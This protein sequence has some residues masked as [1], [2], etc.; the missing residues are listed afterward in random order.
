MYV[1]SAH[2]S[3]VA[4][5]YRLGAFGWLGGNNFFSQGG[6]PNVGL[7]DQSMALQWI[8]YNIG[9]FGGDKDR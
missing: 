2:I 4:I 5:N 6:H 7:H 8:Q 3:Q 9:E 1:P